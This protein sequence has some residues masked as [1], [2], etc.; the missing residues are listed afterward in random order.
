MV[1]KTANFFQANLILKEI[2]EVKAIKIIEDNY[3]I[4]KMV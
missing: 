2:N 4:I 3:L 1:I